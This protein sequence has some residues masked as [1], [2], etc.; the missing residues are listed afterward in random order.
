MIEKLN[1]GT[2]AGKTERSR[3]PMSVPVQ[4][5]EVPEIPGFHLH[6]FKGTPERLQRALDAGYEYVEEQEVKLNSV[7]LGGD[8][9]ASGNTDMGSRVSIVSGSDS[10]RDGQAVR[11]IL[12]K[13]KQEWWEEDQLQIEARNDKVRNTLLGGMIGAEQDRPG[14]SQHRYVDKA[15]TQIPEFFKRKR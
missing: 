13:L 3:V 15:R 9:A 6:W 10:G 12:M 11:L 5:L 14:D 2:I 8:S 1:P 7:S 4:K